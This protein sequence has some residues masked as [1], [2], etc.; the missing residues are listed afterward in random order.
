MTEDAVRTEK[1]VQQFLAWRQDRMVALKLL[2][3]RISDMLEMA[4]HYDVDVE[5]IYVVLASAPRLADGTMRGPGGV[6]TK[7]MAELDEI[8]EGGV[9]HSNR[10]VR[11]MPRAVQMP[12]GL[13]R[14]LGLE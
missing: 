7:R 8:V 13:A 4:K 1:R 10:V 12:P 2:E 11:D 14:L 9:E 5:T 6:D 3:E